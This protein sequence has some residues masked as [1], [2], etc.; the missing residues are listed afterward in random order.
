[1]L[2]KISLVKTI[3]KY[4]KYLSVLAE[5]KSTGQKHASGLRCFFLGDADK[6]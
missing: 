1:M 4:I 2:G 3:Q 6:Y 5:K